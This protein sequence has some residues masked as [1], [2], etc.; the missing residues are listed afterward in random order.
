M[1]KEI[2]QLRLKDFIPF[3]GL[4]NHTQRCLKELDQQEI[5]N[6]SED[7]KIESCIRGVGLVLYN[8]AIAAMAFSEISGLVQL[9]SK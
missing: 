1:T 3:E 8:S 5:L 2:Y 9:L 7:Y 6:L 4:I